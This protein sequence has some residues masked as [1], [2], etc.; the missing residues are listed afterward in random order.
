M[1][2]YRIVLLD[3]ENRTR[4]YTLSRSYNLEELEELDNIDSFFYDLVRAGETPIIVSSTGK[5]VD[6]LGRGIDDFKG[7]AL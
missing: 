1:R 4:G 6:R 7:I 3:R 2:D 5:R